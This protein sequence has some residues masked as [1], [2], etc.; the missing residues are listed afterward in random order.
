[1]TS[2]EM[3]EYYGIMTTIGSLFSPTKHETAE[4]AIEE[5]DQVMTYPD[6]CLGGNGCTCT[7]VLCR[8]ED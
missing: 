6:C 4:A 3:K 1:M 5:H 2:D 7:V 8:E